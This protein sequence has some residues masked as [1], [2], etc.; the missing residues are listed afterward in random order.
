MIIC[1]CEWWVCVPKAKKKIQEK[2]VK[3][4]LICER[5]RNSEDYCN[6]HSVAFKNLQDSYDDWV[7]AYGG[8]S[9]AEYLEKLIENPAT[10]LWVKEVAELLLAKEKEKKNRLE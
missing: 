6:Y 2:E 1:R 4:C 9:F 3:G 10:G 8:L 5:E 7:E